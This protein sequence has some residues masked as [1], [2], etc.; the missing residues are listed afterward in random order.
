MCG[1]GITA[2][3]A[4]WIERSKDNVLVQPGYD[5]LRVLAILEAAVL[6]CKKRDID[7]PET[8]EALDFLEPLIYPKW[9]IPQY[10]DH[11]GHDRTS[12]VAL[13]GQQQVLRG[14]LSPV[15]VIQSA[16]FSE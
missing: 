6:E 12:Q 2:C 11:V 5:R 13:E 16:N 3:T 8:R 4:L 1:V 9:L 10:R 7:T 14:Q 15:S